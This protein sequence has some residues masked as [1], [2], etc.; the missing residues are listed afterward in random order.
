MPAGCLVLSFDIA[1]SLCCTGWS[2][3]AGLSIALAFI[4][5]TSIPLTMHMLSAGK[6]FQKVPCL[7]VSQT[8]SKFS[9]P[10]E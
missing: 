1:A 8:G 7:S 3:A 5:I 4:D 10:V 6:P 9:S 2:L